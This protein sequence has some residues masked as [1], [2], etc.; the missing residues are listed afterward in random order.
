MLLVIFGG[1]STTAVISQ[2]LSIP[3][4]MRKSEDEMAEE[5]SNN[6][7]SS[8][9]LILSYLRTPSRFDCTIPPRMVS[10]VNVS[11]LYLGVF[12]GTYH[13]LVRS[14]RLQSV[15]ACC[16]S[17]N[18]SSF[19]PWKGGRSVLIDRTHLP[20]VTCKPRLFPNTCPIS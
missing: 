19:I 3:N 10:A 2:L 6:K 4:D 20:H 7:S 1:V 12:R 5:T 9:L 8:R 13:Y 15:M 16:I 11:L 18:S 14:K 17:H